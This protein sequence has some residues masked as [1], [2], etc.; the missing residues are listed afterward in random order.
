MYYLV[1][2]E[3]IKASGLPFY[4]DIRDPNSQIGNSEESIKKYLL[5]GQGRGIEKP[6]DRE[7][8]LPGGRIIWYNKEE[9][10]LKQSGI[11]LQV[12]FPDKYK[13][14]F[15]EQRKRDQVNAVLR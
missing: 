8:I 11:I 12:E 5:N 15:N 9:D 4:E 3:K 2:Y 7:L 13:T 6:S 14:I 1:L 10:E